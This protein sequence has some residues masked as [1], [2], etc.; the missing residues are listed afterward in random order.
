M[1]EEL[2]LLW[3]DEPL[4]TLPCVWWVSGGLMALL[5]LHA[6][7]EHRQSSTE[8]T[9]SRVISSYAPTLKSLHFSQEKLW[10]PS[11]AKKRK[12]LVVEMPETSGNL[13]LNVD[14]EI[15]AIQRNI[16]SSA[17]IKVL[18]NP[19]SA[20]VLQEITAYSL[21]YL[22]VMVHRMLSSPQ[23]TLFILGQRASN[24]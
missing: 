7:G 3:Q 17:S 8:N 10:T 24:Y 12:V 14:D 9:L 16:G 5:P 4:A 18:K 2:R 13:N 11:T 23:K 15:G 1:L 20:A 21:V 6:A 19:T 22:L